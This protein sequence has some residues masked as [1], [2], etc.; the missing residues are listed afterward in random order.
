MTSWTLENLQLALPSV[1]KV[2]ESSGFLF[3]FFFSD[4]ETP[5]SYSGYGGYWG[6]SNNCVCSNK[7]KAVDFEFLKCIPTTTSDL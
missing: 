1:I 6:F 2:M 3:L 5:C 7:N 4:C